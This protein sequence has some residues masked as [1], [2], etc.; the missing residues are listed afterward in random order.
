MSQQKVS[1]NPRPREQKDRYQKSI[2][3]GSDDASVR[4]WLRKM[5]SGF[6]AHAMFA[7]H[8]DPFRIPFLCLCPLFPL[9]FG[10][11]LENNASEPS[12]K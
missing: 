11:V 1:C 7:S 9:V 3:G 6:L 12:E 5:P 4:T 2:P 8:V 10:C